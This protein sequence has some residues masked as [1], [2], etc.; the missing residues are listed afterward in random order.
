MHILLI[1]QAFASIN[2]A[3]G[4]RHHEMARYLTAHGHKVTVITSQVSY[5]TGS[6][7]D[8]ESIVEEA[9]VKIIR[10]PVST[11]LHKSFLHRLINFF[12]FMFASN[13]AGKQVE[14]VD[15]IW[16]TSPPLFQ[17]ITAWRLARKKKV[18]FLFEIRDL[19][20]EFAIAI[21]VLK[22]PILIRLSYWLEHLL[23][24][25][26]DRIVVNSPGYIE[27]VKEKGG[28]IVD[29]VPNGADIS[30][31]QT[32]KTKSE[33]RA[34]LGI[35]A[36]DF[37]V[38]YAG[39]HGVSNDLETVLRAAELL[40]EH[41]EIRFV[42]VGDGKE[43]P[44]LI[45]LAK[46]LSL[47]NVTFM[48]PVPKAEMAEILAASDCC[49]AILKN[50]PMYRLTYPNKVFDYMAAGKP[51]LLAIGGVVAEVIEAE[52]AGILV[53]PGDPQS[54]ANGVVAILQNPDR[55]I[56]MG[57]NGQRAIQDRYSRDFNST[58][59]LRIIEEMG[60]TRDGRENFGG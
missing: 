60:G 5:L 14:D 42:F 16:G 59:F 26:A 32:S 3:G 48:S 10:V 38:L 37:V 29:L 55:I 6:K 50:I 18:P 46:D 11:S 2:E 36:S 54:L 44:N 17:G 19:W 27:P 51:V 12:S 49:V 24:R 41:S 8:S 34:E 56:T 31:F 53:E 57:E 7:T 21:G 28:R 4:T 33:I 40:K 35:P 45:Q 9:G 20:P 52:N 25:S 22:N 58:K 47:R 15:L 30:M 39:A 43:K 1:H 23:Y 13:K